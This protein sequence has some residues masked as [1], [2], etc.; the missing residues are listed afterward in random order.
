MPTDTLT[1]T[2]LELWTCIGIHAEERKIEQRLL[3]TV[4]MSVDAKT[5]AKDDSVN[6]SINYSDVATDLKELATKERKTIERF[7]EDAAQMILKKHRADSVAM[8]V[9]KFALQRAE[10]VAITLVRKKL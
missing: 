9:K 5:A 8:T 7:A 6:Q 1:I 2:N 4:E 3:V 10:Y